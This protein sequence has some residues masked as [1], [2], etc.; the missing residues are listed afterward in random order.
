MLRYVLCSVHRIV[1]QALYRCVGRCLY[2]RYA[3]DITAANASRREAGRN[4]VHG[5]YEVGSA[6]VQAF[7]CRFGPNDKVVD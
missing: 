5:Q 4:L 6:Y 2:P 3:C 7:N 1:Y